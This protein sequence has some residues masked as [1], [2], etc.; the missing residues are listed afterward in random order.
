MIPQLLGSSGDALLSPNVS[1]LSADTYILKAL[2]VRR[3][4]TTEKQEGT[5][6]FMLYE[7]RKPR[8]RDIKSDARFHYKAPDRK[9]TAISSWGNNTHKQWR[10]QD[11][12]LI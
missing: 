4:R 7:I 2:E 10:K 1:S 5:S 12:G 8:H 9:G 3:H 6:I 11:K